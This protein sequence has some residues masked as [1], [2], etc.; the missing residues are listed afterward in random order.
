[1]LPGCC[2][3]HGNLVNWYDR[4]LGSLKIRLNRPGAPMRMSAGRSGKGREQGRGVPRTPTILPLRRAPPR[5]RTT[6]RRAS[7][8]PTPRARGPRLATHSE[9]NREKNR[10]SPLTRLMSRLHDNKELCWHAESRTV[11]PVVE[12]G[13]SRQETARFRGKE[14]SPESDQENLTPPC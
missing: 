9:V 8:K 2:L 6:S 3:S 14:N 10:S 4:P 7:S 1:M 5:R 13:Q 11:L 12:D